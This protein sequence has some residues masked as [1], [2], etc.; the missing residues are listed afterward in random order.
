MPDSARTMNTTTEA[1]SRATMVAQPGTQVM[2]VIVLSHFVASRSRRLTPCSR[3]RV[4]FSQ[5]SPRVAPSFLRTSAE[6]RAS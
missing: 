4:V 3:S 2:S 6:G 5:F 1:M